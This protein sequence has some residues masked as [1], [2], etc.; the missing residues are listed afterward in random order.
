MTP[1]YEFSTYD[2]ND[3]I[4]KFSGLSSEKVKELE[5][6]EKAKLE[7]KENPPATN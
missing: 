3:L 4:F 7:A 5:E 2:R 1:E 6:R